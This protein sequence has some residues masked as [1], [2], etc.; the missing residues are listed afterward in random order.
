MAG[1]RR[2]YV[3]LQ[4]YSNILGLFGPYLVQIDVFESFR[5]TIMAEYVSREGKME[6]FGDILLRF[7]CRRGLTRN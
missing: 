7:R 6:V 2:S 5:A 1:H 3:T 4:I